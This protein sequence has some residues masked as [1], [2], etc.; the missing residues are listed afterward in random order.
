MESPRL[1]DSLQSAFGG[2]VSSPRKRSS[3]RLRKQD[4]LDPWRARQAADDR[5]FKNTVGYVDN[6]VCGSMV[7][8]CSYLF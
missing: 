6:V 4:K 3:G 8:N 2:D 7:M 5:N 1:V